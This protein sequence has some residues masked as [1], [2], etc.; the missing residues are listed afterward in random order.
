MKSQIR[1]ENDSGSKAELVDEVEKKLRAAVF[2]IVIESSRKMQMHATER[3]M[4]ERGT[5]SET[6]TLGSKVGAEAQFHSN[7]Y[8]TKHLERLD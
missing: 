6:G 2:G 1:R 5:S 7:R 8:I 3:L 4:G